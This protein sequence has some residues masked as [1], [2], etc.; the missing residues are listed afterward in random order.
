[1]V[2][3]C[4]ASLE[5]NCRRSSLVT[6]STTRATPS[7]KV[8]LDRLER[9]P[10]VLHRVVQQRGGHGLRVEAQ[11]GHDGR[12]GHRVRD[13]GLAR[14]PELP[15]VGRAARCGPPRRSSRCRPRAGAGRTRPAAAPA[16]RAAPAPVPARAR[17]SCSVPGFVV[18]GVT[19]ARVTIH[20][21]YP[22]GETLRRH[23]CAAAA[24]VSGLRFSAPLALALARPRRLAGRPG[25]P[26]ARGAGAGLGGPVPSASP[27]GP[28]RHRRLRRRLPEPG[29]IGPLRLPSRRTAAARRGA[30]A[31]ADLAGGGHAHLGAHGRGV[32]GR[33]PPLRVAPLGQPVGD[34]DPAVLALLHHAEHRA[35]R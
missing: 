23:A 8:S 34:R 17:A 30:P 35:R 32:D 21:G 13:V 27:V 15:L 1:M 29:R 4:C 18:A 5:S 31:A 9:Q 16:G 11:L 19:R 7:P 24:T 14:A 20:P 33:V 10:G 25:L 3:A 22:P 26:A 12:H 28:V 2:A 6:P